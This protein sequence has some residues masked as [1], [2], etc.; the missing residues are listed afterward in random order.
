MICAELEV[1]LSQDGDIPCNI[2]VAALVNKGNVILIGPAADCLA[3]DVPVHLR[4]ICAFPGC[5]NCEC[6][7]CLEDESGEFLLVE[8]YVVNAVAVEVDVG[9]IG[10]G[11]I[12]LLSELKEFVHV[13]GVLVGCANL[14]NPLGA[15]AELEVDVAGI[16]TDVLGDSP[17]GLAFYVNKIYVGAPGIVGVPSDESVRLLLLFLALAGD[18]AGAFVEVEGDD[19]SLHDLRPCVLVTYAICNLAVE[20]SELTG[21]PA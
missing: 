1:L 6:G 15:A 21:P 14:R 12:G 13:L 17:V 16:C 7:A 4:S 11:A 8:V 9:R 20:D 3:N 18:G 10:L 2:G 19:L 5:R